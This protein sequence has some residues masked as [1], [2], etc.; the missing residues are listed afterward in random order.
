LSARHDGPNQGCLRPIATTSVFIKGFVAQKSRS[1]T[2]SAATVPA[3]Y[4][5][6]REPVSAAAPISAEF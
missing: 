3:Q 6:E 5:R 4:W 1:L 2:F